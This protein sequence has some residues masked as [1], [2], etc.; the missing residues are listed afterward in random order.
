MRLLGTLLRRLVR[1]GRLV[2][3]DADGTSHTFGNADGPAVTLRFRDRWAPALIAMNPH[4]RFGEAFMDG[5]FTIDPPARIADVL[6]LLMRNLGL[7]HGGGHLEWIARLRFLVRRWMQRNNEWRARRNASHH[8]DLSGEMYALFLDA[9]RQYSCA[10]FED[11]SDSLEQAQARKKAR[12]TAKLAL[13]PGMKVLDIGSGWGGL[14]LHLARE[15]GADV[16]GITLSREQWDAARARAAAEGM[17]TRVRFQLE[18]YRE[19]QGA[20]DR[21]VS[22][23]MFEHVGVSHYPAFFRKVASLLAPSGAALIHSIGRADGPG[24]SNPWITKYIFPGGYT[25][26]LSEVLPAVERAG[27]VVTDVEVL[28]MHYAW[29]LAEWRRRFVVNWER[30]KALYDERFC[31]MWEFFLAAEEMGFRHQGLMVFQLQV[32]RRMDSLPYTRTYMA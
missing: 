20:F 18:D 1:D 10:Y 6:D 23:G 2:V 8:Y 30:A 21:I 11:P 12:I 27:L 22:V 9:D 28:R 25:P 13:A 3:V 5:A 15:R 29:T 19:T 14:A 4:L 32:A 24:V 31:R 16:T 7:E 17:E 26:A